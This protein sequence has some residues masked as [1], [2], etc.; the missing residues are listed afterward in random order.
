LES[1]VRDLRQAP[2]DVLVVAHRGTLGV[3]ERLLRGLDLRDPSVQP[4]EP[5]CFRRVPF[6]VAETPVRPQ[7]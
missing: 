3:L 1:L 7:L 5:G 4:I 2:G 6:V